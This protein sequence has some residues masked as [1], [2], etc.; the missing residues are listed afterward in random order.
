MVVR[1]GSDT[2]FLGAGTDGSVWI[3]TERLG[4]RRLTPR[5]TVCQAVSGAVAGRV[6]RIACRS[7]SG[8]RLLTGKAQ[9]SPGALPDPIT[10]LSDR[11]GQLLAGTGPAV[12]VSAGAA[13][14]TFVGADHAVYRWTDAAGTTRFGGAPT[15]YGSPVVDAGGRVLACADSAARLQ[16]LRAGSTG[17]LTLP[18]VVRGRPGVA[19]DRS[20]ATRYY[21]VGK[22]GGS[23]RPP[24]VPTGRSPGTR[25]PGE[26]GPRRRASPR[27]ASRRGRG[28]HHPLR[29]EPG[30]LGEGTWLRSWGG[31][32]PG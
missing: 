7:G 31:L 3:R 21:V 18:G 15:C 4:F 14:Y 8:R 6:L 22:D 1:S 32:G 25:C 12:S 20:G 30:L 24:R 16:V 13:Q 26:S 2:W 5:G 27:S 11:G 10:R 19:V 28:A 17:Y 23:A 29:A 9:L